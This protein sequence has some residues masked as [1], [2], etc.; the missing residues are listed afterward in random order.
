MDADRQATLPHAVADDKASPRSDDHFE[1]LFRLA[2]TWRGLDP[3]AIAESLLEALV[4]IL[5]LDFAALRFSD[6]VHL[7]LRIGKSFSTTHSAGDLVPSIDSWLGT[8]PEL[9]SA[10]MTV[11]KEV[12]HVAA[13]PLG[14]I[15]SMGSLVVGSRRT[16]FPLRPE[17]LRLKVAAMQAGLACR[18]I[19]ELN[20]LRPPADTRMEKPTGAALA[21]SEWRLN[22]IINTIPAMA[23]S[24][25]P[26]GMLDFC[27]QHFLDFVGLSSSEILGLGFYRIFHPDDMPHLLAAWQEIMASKRAREI[28]GRIRRADGEYRWFTLRQ[29][30]LLDPSGKVSKWYGVVLDIE[31]RKRAEE[32]L[33]HARS[34]LV[35]SE[36]NIRLIVDSLPVLAWVA[37][38]D[39]T[40]EFVNRRWAEYAGVEAEQILEWGFLNFYH[41]DDVA[42]M[43]ETWKD[44]LETRDRM[45]LKGRIRRFD[46]EYR[47]FY[48]SGR[49]ITDANGV[50]RWVGANVDFED[51]QRAED[52][53]KASE[54]RLKLIIDT[55]PVMAWSSDAG[56]YVDFFSK[57]LL[58]FCG[59]RYE[60]VVGEGYS[61][62]FHQ[63]DVDSMLH[64]WERVRSIK[65]GEEIDA[66]VRRAD[67]E[68]RWFTFRQSPLLD[69]NGDVVKWYGAL[70]EIE[71]R[72]RAEDELR[73]SQ[74]EL[75]RVAR[76][77]TL[78][79]LAVS[80]A[81]EVN[82]P[83]MAIVTDAGTCMRWLD[84]AQFDATR[85]R[86]AAERV[87]REGHR[88]G[89]IVAG[90]RALARK[91]PAR[92]EPMDLHQ[93]IRDVL[94]VLNGE[95]RRRNVDANFD[96]GAEPLIVL[97]DRT[98]LQQVLLNLVMN[99]VESM[100]DTEQVGRRLKICSA[101][102][103]DGFGQVSVI[104]TG[105]GVQRG[106]MDR[107][108]DAFFS[109]KPGGIGMG[110]SI[111][112]SI[113]EA[114]GGSVSARN[115]VPRGS[116]F[117]FTV[118]LAVGAMA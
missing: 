47:W 40:A 49:K 92:M 27:N 34:A 66:R 103:E 115:E 71:D 110:L 79:E 78:G 5:E 1:D 114:H 101:V 76:M 57:N 70:I 68:Y 108:F 113:V 38:P 6:T 32:A 56:G 16:G 52:A 59:L 18:E 61:R 102:R 83:L 28:D 42:G 72:K 91:A 67:G 41:P 84:E 77:T 15:A 93:A 22:L 104:D 11:G 88:A 74:N 26:D 118:P 17:W 99:S 63:D 55:I 10:A 7:F 81:H 69:A 90:I 23:W 94:L 89:E 60:D 14:E 4:D 87:V 29:N 43:V 25:T 85:A 64:R 54:Q 19:R 86:Q 9:G 80:I 12:L 97:G 50:V 58:D 95:F 39:G 24:A 112:R 45:D 35:A 51:L 106:D 21:E 53:L 96:V 36:Q 98:Q 20:D 46:G 111:C 117:S 62:M 44:A 82:Q 31:D 109:T 8:H 75:A 105:T 33:K 73:Q 48:F 13:L 37:R 116:T 107:I 65:R 100:A 2:S 3:T 30:P